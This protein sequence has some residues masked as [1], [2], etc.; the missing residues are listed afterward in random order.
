MF[1][2]MAR[3]FVVVVVLLF[4]PLRLIGLKWERKGFWRIVSRGLL[5]ER[6]RL[7]SRPRFLAYYPVILHT[8]MQKFAQGVLIR[9]KFYFSTEL[10]ETP[11]QIFLRAFFMQDF[12]RYDEIILLVFSN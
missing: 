10:N 5:L 9:V 8:Y 4:V 1:V 6:G 7:F 12:E 2:W 11:V 3:N